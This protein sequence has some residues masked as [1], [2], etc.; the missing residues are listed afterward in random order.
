MNLDFNLIFDR[1]RQEITEFS[2]PKFPQGLN[3][4]D[5]G[6]SPTM[7]FGRKIARSIDDLTILDDGTVANVPGGLTP[8]DFKINRDGILIVAAN[9]FTAQEAAVFITD[10]S[11]VQK[12]DIVIGNPA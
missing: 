12:D 9:E 4:W 10:E 5:V 7:M 2:R 6:N 1:T 3:I 11:G 8:S